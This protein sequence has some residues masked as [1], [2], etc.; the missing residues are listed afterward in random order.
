MKEE[1]KADISVRPLF[2]STLLFFYFILSATIS[3]TSF[4]WILPP[5][6]LDASFIIVRQNGQPTATVSAPVDLASA[7]RDSLTRAVPFSSSFHICA[8]PAP[9]QN[10]LAP[11]RGISMVVM[12]AL[13]N[14]VRGAS[15]IL[16]C[17][18]R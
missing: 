3:A 16:L 17:R 5:S 12:P 14:V 8:P 7:K 9:Q 2:T 6:A 13:S 18:P 10:D 1:K 11:L 4:T 15:V